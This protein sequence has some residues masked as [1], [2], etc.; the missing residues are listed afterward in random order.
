MKILFVAS[1]V[2]PFSKT[3]GLGDVAGALPAA[4]AARGHE[5]HV[6]T[7]R[8]GSVDPSR[9][10]LERH[11]A[12]VHA[13]GEGGALLHGRMGKAHVY[14]LEHLR[15]FGQRQGLYGEGGRDYGDNA[16]RFAYLTRAALDL[17]RALR[18]EPDIVHLHDWQTA[19]GAWLVRHEHAH[20]AWSRRARTVYTIH[21]LAYQGVFPKEL[22]PAIGLPWEVFRYEAV[23][24]YDQLNFMKAGLVF[25]DALTT[26]SPHYARE[27]LTPEHGHDLDGVLRHRARH[28]TGILNGIDASW[29]PATD[30]H[31]PARFSR[32]DLAGKAACKEALQA[33]LGLPQRAGVPLVAMVGRLAEQK[34]IDLVAAALGQLTSLDLQLAVLGSGDPRHEEVLRRA[35]RDRPEKMAV[36][37]GFDEGLAHRIEAGAD[38]FLMPSRF[39]PCG[40]NQ[41]YSLRYGTVPVVRAVGGLEDTVEDFDGHRSGTGFKFREYHPQAL[42]TA[43]RRA[44]DVHRDAT[45][46]RG[47]QERGMALDFSW[48]KSAEAYERLFARLHGAP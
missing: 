30:K 1:E 25:A 13:R 21:N 11:P 5:V 43:L 28:L 47:L 8:Y 42:L 48:D 18:F 46:W 17:P 39:E 7:P 23:E 22:V 26:V 9:W 16:Q 24:F 2:A 44:L 31:L 14:L 29:D 40:L 6:V 35:A 19:L 36:R 37:I 15:F 12:S 41:M 27:I 4:L 45:A 32:G 3:G 20:E 38:V 10:R 34:G 33:E